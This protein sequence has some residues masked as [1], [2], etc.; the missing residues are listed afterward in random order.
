MSQ[1][2]STFNQMGNDIQGFKKRDKGGKKEKKK[3]L[4]FKYYQLGLLFL[5]IFIL[6]F[7]IIA[8]ITLYNSILKI[9]RKNTAA[10]WLKNFNGIF[11]NMFGATL[12]ISC[13]VD[14][15][16]GD[17]C[18]SIISEFSQKFFPP[19][20]LQHL[21]ERHPPLDLVRYLFAQNQGLCNPLGTVR[22]NILWKTSSFPSKSSHR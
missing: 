7:E 22:Q 12:T 5:A 18:S 11:N 3:N 4:F 17:K 1:T 16:R 6:L 15:P 14:T 2:S 19:F 10:T 21:P 13:L 8:H 9:D 20:P